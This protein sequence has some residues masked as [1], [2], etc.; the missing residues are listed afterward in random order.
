MSANTQNKNAFSEKIL[1]RFHPLPHTKD[2]DH[3]IKN[4]KT[5]R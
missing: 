5:G 2:D 3:G 4:Q 1:L